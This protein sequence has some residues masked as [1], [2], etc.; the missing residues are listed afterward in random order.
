MLGLAPP[1][2]TL[3]NHLAAYMENKKWLHVPCSG[4]QLSPYISTVCDD[5]MFGLIIMLNLNLFV[6][7]LNEIS[8]W[9]Y[10]LLVAFQKN[11]A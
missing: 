4:F 1:L 5:L 11:V 3:A 6:S 7:F 2:V 9:E 10:L 8:R